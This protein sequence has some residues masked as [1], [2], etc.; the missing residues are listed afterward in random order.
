ML[1]PYTTVIIAITRRLLSSSSS[2]NINLRIWAR[3]SGLLVLGLLEI[4]ARGSYGSTRTPV[5][6]ILLLVRNARLH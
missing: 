5:L 6:T 1:L 4:E 2:S 3:F